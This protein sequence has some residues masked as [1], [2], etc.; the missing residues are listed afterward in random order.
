MDARRHANTAVPDLEGKYAVQS[1]GNVSA[2]VQNMSISEE[3]AVV[4]NLI[5][6]M[7]LFEIS[8]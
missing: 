7:Y 8:E 2:M 3:D 5:S 1:E 6:G 4:L